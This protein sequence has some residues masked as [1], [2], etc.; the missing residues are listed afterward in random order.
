VGEVTRTDWMER[1]RHGAAVLGGACTG[2]WFARGIGWI[3]DL[4]GL[5]LAVIALACAL[6]GGAAGHAHGRTLTP[7]DSR[8]RRDAVLGWSVVGALVG[9][10]AI[11][12][13]IWS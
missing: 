3:L 7:L 6:L 12:A 9:A 1:I 2:L 4:D 8:E 5:V 13:L 11:G 10:I